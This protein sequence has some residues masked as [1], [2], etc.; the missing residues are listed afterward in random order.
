[1]ATPV[2]AAAGVAAGITA[3]GILIGR[4]VWG[5]HVA[6][7]EKREAY[8]KA[9]LEEA[10]RQYPNYNVALIHTEH[11]VAGQYVHQHV[12]VP[13]DENNTIGYEVYFS[14]KGDPFSLDNKGDGGWINWGYS[15]EFERKGNSINAYTHA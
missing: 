6:A 11:D 8:V 14:K 13:T 4:H 3:L 15:G 7:N 2:A 9:F 12:E 1:M 10:N 5:L